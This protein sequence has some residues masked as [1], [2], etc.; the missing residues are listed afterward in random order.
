[1]NN[2]YLYH[3]KRINKYVSHLIPSVPYNIGTGEES[4]IPRICLSPSIENCIGSLNCTIQPGDYIYVYEIPINTL[5][6]DY[7]YS[8][9]QIQQWVPDAKH[10]REYWYT[11]D[12]YIEPVLCKIINYDLDY[13]INWNYITTDKV[14]STYK[15]ESNLNGFDITPK[16]EEPS[17]EYYNRLYA[18]AENS[19]DYDR[20][21]TLWEL[22]IEIPWSQ[23]YNVKDLKIER[24]SD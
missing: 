11:K 17:E 5:D 6:L 20:C 23:V 4:Q 14:Y 21:D 15:N 16:T 19:G 18:L 24:I 3:I 10:Y 13:T 2:R 1:M 8:P 12:I 22:L 9:I 7:L